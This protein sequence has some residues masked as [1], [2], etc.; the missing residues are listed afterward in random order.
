MKASFTQ[1]LQ[2][3]N[4]NS[5]IILILL[6]I[7]SITYGQNDLCQAR[8]IVDH[9]LNI[10]S[11]NTDGAYYLMTVTNTASAADTFTFSSTNIN[12]TC[13][14]TD[15]SSSG[16]NIN[17]DAAFVDTKLNPISAISLNPGQ[18]YSFY[19]HIIIPVG[20]ETKKWC[21]T[22]IFAQSKNCLDYKVNTIVH[23]YYSGPNEN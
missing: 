21:C 23:T 13:S 4:N 5:K 18:T 19:T 12:T 22:Q 9:D 11:S 15:G 2:S 16:H 7:S 10:G 3:F 20:S 17:L 1:Y 6:L 14:N 8:L